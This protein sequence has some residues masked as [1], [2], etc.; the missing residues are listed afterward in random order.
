MRLESVQCAR[1]AGAVPLPCGCGPAGRGRPV[2]G[3]AS[4][5]S[6]RPSRVR[7]PRVRVARVRRRWRSTDHSELRFTFFVSRTDRSV[8][9]VLYAGDRLLPHTQTDGSRQSDARR[10]AERARS[11]VDT[12]VRR[13]LENRLEPTRDCKP[14]RT[15]RGRPLHSRG[16][17]VLTRR[18]MRT[19]TRWQRLRAEVHRGS[20]RAHM[21]RP[22]KA[23]RRCRDAT[24]GQAAEVATIMGGSGRSRF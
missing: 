1:A 2:R 22:R 13:V 24:C 9:A 14:S 10:N 17:A 23:S 20:S 5:R 8:T 4:G 3:C 11:I 6:A 15:G 19:T 12:R 7:G 18:T 21:R 16:A